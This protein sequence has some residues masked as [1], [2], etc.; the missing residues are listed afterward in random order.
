[1]STLLCVVAILGLALPDHTMNC[2]I[3]HKNGRRYISIVGQLDSDASMSEYSFSLPPLIRSYN[4]VNGSSEHGAITG[5]YTINRTAKLVLTVQN[6]VTIPYTIMESVMLASEGIQFLET[7]CPDLSNI[8]TAYCTE[9]PEGQKI[10][11][12]Y[13]E[14]EH[15]VATSYYPSSHANMSLS[16]SITGEQL[17][18]TLNISDENPDGS[19]LNGTVILTMASLLYDNILDSFVQ[20]GFLVGRRNTTL[21]KVFQMPYNTIA[22]MNTNSLG[23]LPEVWFS[24]IEASNNEAALN[25]YTFIGNPI[26]GINE[27][28]YY[29]AN[30]VLFYANNTF[31]PRICSVLNESDPDCV[32][33]N[34]NKTQTSQCNVSCEGFINVLHYDLSIDAATVQVIQLIGKPVIESTVV[35]FYGVE[36]ILLLKVGNMADA[37]GVVNITLGTCF[38]DY[39]PI[40]AFQ[41]LQVQVDQ[42]LVDPKESVTFLLLLTSGMSRF[43][44]KKIAHSSGSCMVFLAQGYGSEAVTVNATAEWL[45]IVTA[46]APGTSVP[47]NSSTQ[48]QPPN[49][50][51]NLT[52]NISTASQHVSQYCLIACTDDQAFVAA[53]FHTVDGQIVAKTAPR[54]TPCDCL[55]KYGPTRPYFSARLG[56]C[57]GPAQKALE[58]NSTSTQPYDVPQYLPFNN[59]TVIC[60]AHGRLNPCKNVLAVPCLCDVGYT[61]F[62]QSSDGT[63]NMCLKD[64]NIPN[65]PEI[66]YGDKI[67]QGLYNWIN[68]LKK[69][70]SLGGLAGLLR[71]FASS[72]FGKIII[73]IVGGIIGIVILRI[74]IRQLLIRGVSCSSASSAQRARAAERRRLARSQKTRPRPAS[75]RYHCEALSSPEYE[76]VATRI[77]VHLHDT[78][79]NKLVSRDTEVAEEP[80]SAVAQLNKALERFLAVD[81]I[82]ITKKS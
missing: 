34:V 1:M 41:P 82:K 12:L 74:V 20:N 7:P 3:V 68:N 54:C 46:G 37:P 63:Y 9:T 40:G 52:S 53:I 50:Y 21:E 66:T 75:D 25:Q 36:T 72:T 16:I 78:A 55:Q 15:L 62:I 45:G 31:I 18:E 8:M 13:Q 76:L 81:S 32:F 58:D 6:Y 17:A 47:V 57:I 73:G 26:I 69:A 24:A 80:S 71:A 60:G 30:Q 39:S 49:V 11:T 14:D 44:A 79:A 48:C 43:Q 77:S 23:M 5:V 67:F 4:K 27:T 65:P 42:K 59:S 70:F 56:V 64:I 51:Y 22:I 19:A 2:S 61:R 28:K 38:S 33:Q 10:R 29:P 35:Q